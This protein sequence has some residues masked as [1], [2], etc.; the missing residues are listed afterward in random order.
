MSLIMTIALAVPSVPA[1]PVYATAVTPATPV[2][3]E[4]I[5]EGLTWVAGEVAV[6]VGTELLSKGVE[7]FNKPSEV[8]NINNIKSAFSA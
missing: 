4:A 7:Y 1:M 3:I 5:K 6:G 8:S 2:I